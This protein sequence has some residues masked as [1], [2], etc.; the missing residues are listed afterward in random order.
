MRFRVASL[1]RR[2]MPTPMRSDYIRR[3]DGW[4]IGSGWG[5]AAEP[6]HAAMNRATSAIIGFIGPF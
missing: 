6:P 3:A 5:S 1:G 2:P 4:V